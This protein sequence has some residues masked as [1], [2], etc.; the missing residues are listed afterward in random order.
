MTQAAARAR[1]ERINFHILKTYAARRVQHGV[2]VGERAPVGAARPEMDLVLISGAKP[3]AR[4]KVPEAATV[5]LPVARRRVPNV[6]RRMDERDARRVAA[7]RYATATEKVGSVAGA[8]AEG[9]KADGGAAT[10]D[11]GVTTRILHAGTISAVERVLSAAGLAIQPGRQDAG[12]ARRAI[13]A[14]AL[15]DAICLEGRD[16]RSVLIAAGWSGHRRDV[17]RLNVVAREC[18]EDMARALGLVADGAPRP[19]FIMPKL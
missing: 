6:L 5:G 15:I 18:L 12:S 1:A 17:A 8:S 4:D 7:D 10:T 13:S 3:D 9:F 11:G 19:G 16:M 2:S 14:R